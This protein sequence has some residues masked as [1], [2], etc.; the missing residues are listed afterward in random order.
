MHE[1]V[2]SERDGEEDAEV[3]DGGAP[4]H[5]RRDVVAM[6]EHVQRGDGADEPRG[7]G[8]R[9]RRGGHGL[10]DVRLEGGE[11]ALGLE[12]GED[13]DADRR[14]EHAPALRP[15]RLQPEAHVHGAHDES[16]DHA[17]DYRARAQGVRLAR[18]HRDDEGAPGGRAAT[19]ARP[20]ENA[21]REN[22]CRLGQNRR[23][24]FHF[25]QCAP[26]AVQLSPR[27]GAGRAGKSS[28]STH[29]RASAD[30][31][32]ARVASESHPLGADPDPRAGSRSAWPRRI[33][34]LLRAIRGSDPR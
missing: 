19:S 24:G 20:R 27:D 33:R 18:R 7:H 12:R 13:A 16:D 10:R 1:E 32:A 11:R 17:R 14:G 8:H 25:Q 23:R 22:A 9:P 5:D 15:P 6:A 29:A 31:T 4:E 2:R 34:C 21:C 28:L 26:N 3:G 30:G